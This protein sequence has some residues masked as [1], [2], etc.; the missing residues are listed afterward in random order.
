M[1]SFDFWYAV[2]HTRLVVRPRQP[3]ETFGHTTLKYHLVTEMPDSVDRIRVREGRV[4]AYRPQL[5]TTDMMESSPLEGFDHPAASEYLD[6]L[7]QHERDMA[8]LKYGFRIRKEAFQEHHISD[9]LDAVVARVQKSL[10]QKD[11]PMSALVVGVDDPWEV[12]LL[13]MLMEVM[14][15]SVQHNARELLADP[16]GSRH[17]IEA[18]FAAAARDRS[19]LSRLADLLAKKNLFPEYEDRFFAL[20][21][22]SGS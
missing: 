5:I 11:E 16:D 14:Q 8:V 4:L 9:K 17:E 13:R 7:R 19:R 22:A 3:L 6:W 18:A 2:N 12:C 21:R 10:R 20:V 1:D 15:G